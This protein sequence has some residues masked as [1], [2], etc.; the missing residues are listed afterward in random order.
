[1]SEVQYGE[2]ERCC[3]KEESDFDTNKNIF[4]SC[5]H[6]LKQIS[7]TLISQSPKRATLSLMCL[8]NTL[9]SS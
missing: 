5:C 4:I 1:M 3:A 6:T 7:A 9:L 8:C 2:R